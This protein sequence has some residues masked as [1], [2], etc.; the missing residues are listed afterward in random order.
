MMDTLRGRLAALAALGQTISYGDLARELAL[1][2]PAIQ[3]LAAMLEGLM[4]EDA[5]KGRPFLAA[6]MAGRLGDGLPAVGFFEKAAQLDAA[7]TADP[8]A[9]VA[10]QRA[11]LQKLYHNHLE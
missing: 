8:A 7:M 11:D 4:E 1:P 10:Q 3:T 5:A 6:V 2:S 9:F